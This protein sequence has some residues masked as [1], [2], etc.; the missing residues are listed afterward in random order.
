MN[1]Q[2]IARIV[3]AYGLSYTKLL[4]IEKGYRNESHPFLTVG[5]QFANLIIYKREPN[6]LQTIR[7]ANRSSNYLAEKGFPVRRTLDPRLICLQAGNYRRYAGLYNYLPGQTIPW[8]GYTQQHIKLLGAML[9]NMHAELKSLSINGYPSVTNQYLKYWQVMQHYFTNPGV[10]TALKRKLGLKID[11]ETLKQIKLILLASQQLHQQQ[12][13]HLDFVRSNILFTANQTSHQQA[14]LMIS[15]VLDF[16]KTAY[17]HPLFDIARSLAFLLVDCKYKTEAQVR[18]YFLLSGYQKRGSS[19][20][21]HVKLRGDNQADDLLERL[22]DLFLLY[23]FY[24]FLK[25]NPYEDL[26][27][28]EHF[29]RTQNIL[30]TRQMIYGNDTIKQS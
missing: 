7:L 29:L 14:D 2:L 24:K 25:H 13:L 6:I 15:G 19:P 18:K 11:T 28:N 21:P 9:S 8:E 30:L 23:D 16:E 10:N 22:I 1:E 27:D 20:L 3:K 12:V 17:G 4:P 5:G 26:A